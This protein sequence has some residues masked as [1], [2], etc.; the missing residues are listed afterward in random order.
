M[1]L[2][3][4]TFNIAAGRQPDLKVIQRQVMEEN[5][6]LLGLQEVDCLTTRNPKEMLAEIGEG[7]YPYQVYQP[8]FHFPE[9]GEYGNGVLSQL[10]PVEVNHHFYAVIGEEPRIYQEII[11]EILNHRRL[12]FY[13]T[14]LSFES[15]EI[16]EQQAA[17]LND[18][19]AQN[20]CQWSIVLGDFNFDQDL[21][22]WA[23][24]SNFKWCN[25]NQEKWW[26]TFLLP[27][28]TM[29]NFAIDNILVTKNCRIEQVGLKE[30]GL[31]DHGLFWAEIVLESSN[32]EKES[33]ECVGK[34]SI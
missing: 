13:N 29:K 8:A 21:Q 31:S 28:E 16:R 11:F 14:H 4:G 22:E 20:Q 1:R 32:K 26:E 23:V 30:T 17:E 34:K 12:A 24:F 6:D 10:Q 5:F 19:V 15:S 25:G 18:R 33:E 27:D 2:K 7:F 9:G 3:V